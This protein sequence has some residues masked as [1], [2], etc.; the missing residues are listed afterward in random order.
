M[1]LVLTISPGVFTLGVIISQVMIYLI[2]HHEV[3]FYLDNRDQL[4]DSVSRKSSSCDKVIQASGTAAI[5]AAVG[6]FGAEMVLK[7]GQDESYEQW[8][9][10]YQT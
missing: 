9:A 3:S 6:F 7:S 1:N 4:K 2:L 8:Y 5:V 10:Y